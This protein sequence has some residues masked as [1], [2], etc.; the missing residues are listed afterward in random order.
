MSL[1]KEKKHRDRHTQ[2]ED[3]S[4]TD[5][6]G[7]C[8]VRMEAE[9]GVSNPATSQGMLRISTTPEEENID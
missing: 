9:T 6:Q 3:D 1:E 2:R 5:R 7:E 4:K 8:Y